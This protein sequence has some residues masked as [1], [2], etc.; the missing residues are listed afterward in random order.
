MKRTEVY[1]ALGSNLGDREANI[2]S[3]LGALR[4]ISE[5]LAV[6]ATYET[7]PSG[8]R[9]QPRF[10]NAVCGAWTGLDPF[11]LLAELKRIEA[12]TGWPRAFVNGPR[13]LDIDILVYG[14]AVFQTPNLTIPH[15]RMTERPFVLRPLAEIAPG[16]RHPV[17][18]ETARALLLRLPRSGDALRRIPARPSDAD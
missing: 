8:F 12:A 16:L 15:P 14:R 6:S 17:S 3:G 10:L 7:T 11:L 4:E 13:L 1:L 9:S 2:A 18:N 5:C